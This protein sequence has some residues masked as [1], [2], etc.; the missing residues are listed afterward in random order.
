MRAM[1]LRLLE[2]SPTAVTELYFTLMLLMLLIQMKC[3]IMRC[4]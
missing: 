1:P 4:T 2:C 3:Q